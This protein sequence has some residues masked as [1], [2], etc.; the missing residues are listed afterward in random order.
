M[1]GHDACAVGIGWLG[2]S[3]E[4]LADLNG[5][6]FVLKGEI[7]RETICAMAPIIRRAAI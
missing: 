6:Y 4:S 3:L 5:A 2:P 7:W 1:Q